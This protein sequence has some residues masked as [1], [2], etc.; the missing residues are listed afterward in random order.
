[1]RKQ[2]VRGIYL[3][4]ALL[5]FFAVLAA[6]AGAREALA[7]RTQAMRQ[8]IA[9]NPSLSRTISV[10]STVSNLQGAFAS[11]SPTGASP[12]VTPSMISAIGGQLRGDFDRSPVTL[13]PAGGDL[14]LMTTG[15]SPV[16]ANM[17]GTGGTMVKIEVTERQPFGPQVRL[18]SGRLP[19][20]DPGDA[21]GRDERPQTAARFGLHAGSKFVM[22]GPESDSTGQVVPITVVVTGIVAPTDPTSDFWTVDP[23]IVAPDLQQPGNNGPHYWAGAVMIGPGE[24]SELENYF[25]SANVQLEWVFP[26]DASSL[27]GQQAQ[28][29]SQR[30]QLPHHSGADALG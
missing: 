25:S 20:R 6:T 19:V 8:T 12:P 7:S 22:T 23:T 26:I 2:A 14:A 13:G 5:T 4:L 3:A 21:S 24:T 29:L 17:P 28:P 18:V 11:A 1:M 30:A 15:L 9:A 16:P 27:T 10:T